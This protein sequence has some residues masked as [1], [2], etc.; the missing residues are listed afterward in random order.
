MS[1][2]S[3]IIDNKSDFSILKKNESLLQKPIKGTFTQGQLTLHNPKP[4]QLACLYR[5]SKIVSELGKKVDVNVINE[6]PPLHISIIMCDTTTIEILLS[7]K[8]NQN[9]LYDGLTPLHTA[10]KYSDFT[11]FQYCLMKG[12]NAFS[13]DK[14]GDTVMHAAIR[15]K[16]IEIIQLLISMNIRTESGEPIYK[17]KNIKGQTPLELSNELNIELPIDDDAQN[18]QNDDEAIALLKER[19]TVLE[20]AVRIALD[21]LP[22][23]ALKSPGPCSECNREGTQICPVCHQIFCKLDWI[24][25]VMDGCN[26][27]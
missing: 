26:S 11:T 22:G 1:I 21:K 27:Q 25:H 15:L 7:L 19:V 20:K 4:I 12:F 3:L 17:Y 10:L 2:Q 6:V 8:A 9:I 18:N 14:N 5:R 16:K 24:T 13:F 23:D